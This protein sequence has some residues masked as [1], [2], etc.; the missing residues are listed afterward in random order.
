MQL[1][2]ATA[3]WPLLVAAV[4]LLRLA[5]LLP[6]AT[7]KEFFPASACYDWLYHTLQQLGDSDLIQLFVYWA[8]TTA[9]GATVWVLDMHTSQSI[10]SD[11]LPVLSLSR[12]LGYESTAQQAKGDILPVNMGVCG[13]VSKLYLSFLTPQGVVREVKKQHMNM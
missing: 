5:A 8:K 13:C 9:L 4:W 10:V 7:E 12:S 2:V 1:L 6:S 3:C 11:P